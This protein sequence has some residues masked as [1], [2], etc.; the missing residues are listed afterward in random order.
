MCGIWFSVGFPADP[1]HI[2]IVEHRGPD[3]RG[4]E[5][6]DSAFGPIAL[7]HRR[8]SIIDLSGAA[9]Q[10]MAYRGGRYQIVYNGEI[11]NYIALR[12]ELQERGHSFDTQSDTEVLLAAYAQW[13]EAALDRLVGMFAFVIWDTREQVAFAARDRFGI[14]PLYY[15]ATAR[16]LAFASEIKQFV[17]LPGFSPKMNIARIYDFLEAGLLDHSGETMFAGVAQLRGGECV[18]IDFSRWRPGEPPPL[19]RWYE[20]LASGTLDISEREAAQRLRA[21]LTESVYIH[22]RSDVPVGS[23][24]SGGL[25]SSS[26]VC[27]M[28]RAFASEGNGAA[29]HS[30]SA[31]F[32]V[33]AVDERP[34]MEA[35]V[36]HTGC[37]PH[38]C[39]PRFEDVFAAAERITWHQDE[40]Y[41]ST[42]IF[43]EWSVYKAAR[44]AGIKVML[45]G[46]GADE[47]LAGYHD[48]FAHYYRNLIARRR[49]AM[50]VRALAERHIWHGARFFDEVHTYI[51]PLL[52]PGLARLLPLPSLTGPG[53]SVERDW[54]DSEPFRPHLGR[55]A[56]ETARER[57]DAPPPDGVGELCLLMT[58]GSNMPMQLHW[59]DRD[60]MAHSIEARVP[61]LDHRVVELTI[62]LGERHKVIGGDTKRILRRAMTGILPKKVRK[63]R[64][65]IGFEAPEEAW[66][67]GP[68][69]GA[70]RDGI[71]AAI[72]RYPGLFNATAVRAYVDDML[73]GRRRV[74]E[75][76]WRIVNLGIWGR[77]FG[78]ST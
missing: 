41:S 1:K 25:D 47:Q 60:S 30:V 64:D 37:I 68:L 4:F 33:Q 73:E 14:K 16:G 67:R 42:S 29:V 49:Y 27:L 34:F 15:F 3:G 69:K 21:L 43:A 32:D 65:K 38:W 9:A 24:L 13:G 50:L 70:M 54:L 61:F 22:L 2:D 28:A 48:V 7:G 53:P 76:L 10:P 44:E 5:V 12:R 72:A 74:E 23:L 55:S 77:V 18:R 51:A 39:Y 11:Y 36:E 26:I 59:E 66:F 19:R 57:I 35:V 20:I 31:C 45:E 56:A 8:L 63:R 75:A 17:G 40:P 46:H 71:E 78:V 6:L 62:A 52:P 58:Q